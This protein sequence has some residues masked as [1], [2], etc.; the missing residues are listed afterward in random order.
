MKRLLA[1]SFGLVMLSSCDCGLEPLSQIPGK[2]AAPPVKPDP[3]VPP[4]PVETG[5][6][7]GRVCNPDGTTWLNAADVVVAPVDGPRVTDTSDVDGYFTLDGVSVGPQRVHVTKLLAQGPIEI[8][9]DVTVVANQTVTIPDEQCGLDP[10]LRIAVVHGSNFDRVE[11]VLGDLGIDMTTVDIYQTDWAE[12]LLATDSG[13]DNYDILFLNCRSAEATYM[14]QPAMQ[15][16]LRAFIDRGGALYAA[17]QAYD[18]IEVAFPEKIDFF[19]NDNQRGS[20]DQGDTVDVQASVLDN[21]LATRLGSNTVGLHFG[22][23]TW[24]VMTSV[25][26][27]V[28]VYIKADVPLLDG[29][30]VHDAPMTVGFHH[31]S[32]H[33]VYSSFHEEPGIG[34]GQEQILKLLMFE[35]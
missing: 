10:T 15:D 7:S 21:T 20:G 30:T 8:L 12:Q 16:R 34:T 4:P 5:S 2:P 1:L 26:S 13:L 9:R 23:T 6:I 33:V 11:G 14:A 32:G 29:S 3:V 27:D 19:G 18:I 28:D 24:S 35:L 25:A 17:D 31:G 22:L